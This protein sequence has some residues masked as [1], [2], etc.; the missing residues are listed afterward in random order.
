[1]TTGIVTI[2]LM[3][4]SGF[5]SHV[6]AAVE[7]VASN[8]GQLA[9]PVMGATAFLIAEFLQISYGEVVAAAVIPA[10]VY[11][12]V[13][14][15]QVDLIARK[16]GLH[17]LPKSELPVISRV[18]VKG[19]PYVLPLLVLVYMLFHLGY[20]PGK[21]ALYA[22]AMTV[23]VGLVAQRRWPTFALL[24]AMV[25][26]SGYSLIT[27]LLICAGAGIVIGVLNITGL[28]FSMTN[29]LSHVGESG[30]VLVMLGLT[31]AI[32]IVL[33]MGMPTAAVYI[34]LSIILAPALVKMGL[35]EISAHLF[36]FYFGLLSMLT[37][38]VAVASYAAGGL[39]NAS[40]WA[41]GLAGLRLGASAYLLPFLFCL[42]PALIGQGTW[43]EI[44][45]VFITAMVAGYLLAHALVGRD[46]GGR[47]LD[48][49][50][51]YFVAALVVG[52]ATLW[53]ARD[54]LLALVPAAI[55][56]VV[57]WPRDKP[58]T[59]VVKQEADG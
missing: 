23:V 7:A 12:L 11:Y 17:G 53:T 59:P 42:N 40:L 5:P 22:A 44:G 35:V 1:M 37:P 8:G 54:S 57:I 26:Q 47:R 55:A 21:S 36:I 49:F 51:L 19:W 46:G 34:V 41:T 10:L 3:K 24:R 14:F 30:G 58:G 4:K 16:R 28:G 52:S 29:I 20:S 18:L 27:L 13:L 32:A 25:M 38:P 2:P 45:I 15:L 31:A 39:A 43:L 48:Q 6:A 33:G 56:L 9:P 50:V